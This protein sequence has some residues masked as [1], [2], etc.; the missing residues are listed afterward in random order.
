MRAP[1]LAW[2]I[3]VAAGAAAAQPGPADSFNELKLLAGEWQA[4]L[5]GVG[6]MI[7]SICLVSNGRGIEATIGTAADNK[8]SIYTRDNERILMTHFFAMTPDGHV[9]RFETGSRGCNRA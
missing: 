6:T 7:D 3:A 9:A 8:I 4:Q 1:L 5:P 2:V